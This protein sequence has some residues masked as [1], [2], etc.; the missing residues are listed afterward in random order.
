MLLDPDQRIILRD[1]SWEVFEQ[2][3]ALRGDRA[4]LRMT[5]RTGVLE[6]MSPSQ[7]HEGIKKTLARILEA[8]AME[9]GLEFNGFGS[10][11]LKSAPDERGLEPDECYIVGDQDKERPDLAIEVIWTH[12]GLDKLDVYAGLGVGEVWLWKD[13]VIEVHLL[14]GDGYE[15]AERSRLLPD[16]DLELVARCIREAR[17]Q[18]AAVREFLAV[19]R[20]GR[21]GPRPG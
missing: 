17:S 19:T 13:G 4:G 1:V 12:G 11:T 10:W 14:R 15:R 7:T 20:T 2:L 21:V 9:A 8:Y 16:L 6:I 18:T 5:Y 3:L